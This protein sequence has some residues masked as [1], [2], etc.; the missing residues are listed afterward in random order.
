MNFTKNNISGDH[1]LAIDSHT[2]KQLGVISKQDREKIKEKIK[3]LK[4]GS[5]KEKKRLDK[6]KKGKSGLKSPFMR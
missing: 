2:L 3:E 6:E 5:E 1:L 4:K